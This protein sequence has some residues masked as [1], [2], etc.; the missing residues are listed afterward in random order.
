[1]EKIIF[2][3]DAEPDKPERRMF[4]KKLTGYSQG[5]YNYPGV[6]EKLPKNTWNWI[7]RS[8]ILIDKNKAK[9][10]RKLLKEYD[11]ILDWHEF[12]ITQEVGK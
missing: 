7:N 6:L 11:H 1:M 9:D 4:Y 2:I 12:R 8:T 5:K 3:W 10:L